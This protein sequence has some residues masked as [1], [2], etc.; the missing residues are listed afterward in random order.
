MARPKGSTKKVNL[1]KLK[2]YARVGATQIEIASV[3]GISVATLERR[4]QSKKFRDIL[5]QG[6]NEGYISLRAK[7]YALALA[8]NP[9]MLIWLGKQCLGQ[10]DK[11]EFS[12]TGT[13]GRIEFGSSAVERLEARISQ[14]IERRRES[15]NT[16]G[17]AGS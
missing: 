5:D 14:L 13:D 16:P 1:D 7:Q 17:N 10:K 9:T 2:E 6:K 11:Q 8:G 3:L 12:G 15:G 4:L